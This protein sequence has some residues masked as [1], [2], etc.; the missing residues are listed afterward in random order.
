MKQVWRSLGR[1][2]TP[3]ELPQR[4]EWMSSYAA[5]PFIGEREKHWWKVYFSTRNDEGRSL[6]A[7]VD[8]DVSDLPAVHV[9]KTASKPVLSLGAPGEFDRDGVMGCHLSEVQGRKYLYYI[10]WNRAVEVPFR[11]AIGVAEQLPDGSF[12]KPF[13]GPVL[14]RSIYDPCFVA[15][16]CIININGRW[17]MY[18]LSCDRWE[19]APV[20]GGF[21][22]FYHI[23][24]AVSDDGIHWQRDGRIAIDHEHPGEYAISVPRVIYDPPRYKMWY[25]Y[26][27][28][29]RSPH[30]LIGYAESDDGFHWQRKDGEIVFIRSGEAWDAE[31]VCYP[32]VFDHGKRRYMLY[33]GNGY[34]KTGF[35]L[36]VLE[37]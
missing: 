33:N 37:E 26:R 5:V 31:M 34:G 17:V 6:T 3:L 35:G 4:P 20:K 18:Y 30:Y 7:W 19:P 8:L 29:R 23:K 2:F 13:R 9:L 1:I 10:G 32:F 15:S 14:D 24:I 12:R 22:H 11:N 25:S 16:N 28:S 21:R 36:A 27:G